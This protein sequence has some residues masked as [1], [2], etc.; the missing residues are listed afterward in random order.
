MNARGQ[1]ITESKPNVLVVPPRAIRRSGNNQVVDVRRNGGVEEQIVTTGATDTQQ[2]EILTGLNEGDVVVVASLT[3][4]R[5]G[6]TPKAAAD[7]AR[8]REVTA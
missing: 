2:V 3:S 1:I 6:S 4:A 5:P 7:A 8:R